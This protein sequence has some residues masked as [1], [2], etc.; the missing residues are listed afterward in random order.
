MGR[1]VLVATFSFI[2]HE[3]IH[4]VARPHLE[5]RVFG[6]AS[7]GMDASIGTFSNPILGEGSLTILVKLALSKR[8]LRQVKEGITTAYFLLKSS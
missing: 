4:C 1:Q 6:V 3:L 5:R 8:K 7:I 2:F